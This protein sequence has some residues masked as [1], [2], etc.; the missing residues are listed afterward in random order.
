MPFVS[1]TAP[2]WLAP[3]RSQ[4]VPAQAV[5]LQW[6]GLLLCIAG[7]ILM[8]VGRVHQLFSVL[9]PLRLAILTGI[10]ATVI[11]LLDPQE[12]RRAAHVIGPT[13]TYLVAFL[14]WMVL[15]VP[16]SLRAGNSFDLLFDN[17]IKTVLMYF[18]VAASIRGTRDV[19]RLTLAYLV[20]ATI[21]AAVVIARFD[22]GSGDGWRLGRLYYY[23]ANDFAT[24]MVTAIPLGLYFLHSARRPLPRFAAAASL[25]VLTLSFVRSGSRGGFVALAVVGLFVVLRYS[26][27]P[28]RWRL[29]GAALVAVV[30]FGTASDRYWTQMGTILSDTDYNLKEESGRMEIWRRGIGYM[31]RDPLLGVGP[32]NFRVAEGTMSPY[33]DRQELGI[34]VRWNAAHNSYIQVGA[35]LGIPGLV[36]F[37]ALIGSAFAALRRAGRNEHA[38]GGPPLAPALTA[39]LLGF[40]VGAFFL[41]LAYSE[42]LYTLVALSV[43]LQ[44]VTAGQSQQRD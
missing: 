6:D 13:T 3:N 1:S 21:Y 14:I 44:K 35:E 4:A 29:S 36:L 32:D 28:L 16:G 8:S 43:G 11:Y 2:A 20:A 18:I 25:V 38:L 12:H 7:Y 27:I 19:E 33:A 23:D 31:L 42:M 30:L 10:L 9:E 41:S 5:D 15:S 17:F 37:V 24:L 40:V 22:V 26:A 39:A 34:G